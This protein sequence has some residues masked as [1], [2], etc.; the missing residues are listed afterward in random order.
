MKKLS[1]LQQANLICIPDLLKYKIYW[2]YFS[3]RLG[4]N[5]WL[6]SF[7]LSQALGDPV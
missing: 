6:C 5:L 4:V 3:R 7:C 2:G 1:A